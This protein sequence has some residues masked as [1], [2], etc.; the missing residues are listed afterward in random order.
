MR[1]FLKLFD[2]N[3]L[4][5]VL[6]RMKLLSFMMFAVLAA[7]AADT[8]S[9]SARFDMHIKDASVK[10]VFEHIEE[11]SEFILLYNEKWVD[12]NRKVSV[13]AKNESV[14]TVL[15]KIFEGTN[16]VFKIYDRQIVILNEE[17]PVITS[18]PAASESV[19]QQQRTINGRVTDTENEPLPGVTVLIK[20][21]RQGTVTNPDG[22]YSLSNVPEDAILVFSFVGMRSQEI[23]VDNRSSINVTLAIDAIGLEEIIAV[24]YGTQK[25]VN[26]TGSVSN[27]DV[28]NVESRAVTQSSQMLAGKVSGVTVTQ[29][30]GQPGR[31]ESNIVI[32]GLGTFSSAG[33]QPLVLV[34]GLASSIDNVNP[35][36]IESISVL[37]DAASAS[38]YG[39][40]AAN[41]VILIQTKRGTRAGFNISYNGY[42]GWKKVNEL[43]ENVN[44]WE[45]AMLTNEARNN[46]G[47]GNT[48]SQ[49]EIEL[50]RNGTDP[51]NYPNVNHLE[52]L[53]S[54]GSGF[55]TNHNLSF[56][57]MGDK[58]SYLFSVGYLDE[59][60]LVAKTNYKR[61]N[62]L[63]NFDSDITDNLK[64]AV[65]INGN[66]SSINEP[67]RNLLTN[68]V[69]SLIAYA[70]QVP[71]II[72]DRNS[73]G[74]YDHWHDYGITAIMD[75]NNFTRGNDGFF[76]GSINL[77]WELFD[78]FIL[79]GKLGYNYENSNRDSYQSIIRYDDVY[80]FGPNAL[81]VVSSDNSLIT[82]QAL[83]NYDLTINENNFHFLAGF[84]Q[85]EFRYDFMDAYRDNFPNDLL[86]E[87]DAG[88]AANMR[89]SGTAAEWALRSLFGR[90][91]YSYEG[92]YLLEG[93][94]RYDG[95]SRFPSDNRWAVFPSFSA[96]WRMSEES[97]MQD[98]TWLDNLKLR[99]SW[100][101]LGNQNI[102]NYPYQRLIT[103]GRDYPFGGARYPGAYMAAIANSEIEWERTEMTNIGLDF[104]I[105]N[106]KLDFVVDYFNKYTSGILYNISVSKVLGMGS[107]EVNAGEVKNTGIEAL[108]NYNQSIGNFRFNITPNF[109]YIHNE[110]MKI[111]NAEVDINQGLFVGESLGAI[112][113]YVADGLFVD[114]DDITDY[115]SQPYAVQPG[116]I[117]YKDISGPEGVPDGQVDPQYDRTVIGTRFPKFN[118]GLNV[119]ASYANFDFSLQL[120]GI[121]GNKNYLP[122]DYQQTAFVNG[123]TAQRWQMENRWTQ[124]NPDRNAEYPIMLIGSNNGLRF[125]STYWLRDAGFLQVKNLQIG[126][127]LPSNLLSSIGI[128]SSRIYVNG[129][130][131]YRF[132]NYYPGWDPEM[133]SGRGNGQFYPNTATYSLGLRVNF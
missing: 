2:Q 45:H 36:D 91:N 11:N 65:N 102:G 88:S 109:S 100:G 119:G 67:I 101:V 12:V 21:T 121:A 56:S 24:G 15:Q 19:V 115:P 32:R 46:V 78:N 93:N 26:L 1:N 53:L 131:I 13:D 75:N 55:Q 117:R 85:E 33:T 22:N 87:L 16:N 27:V 38:I 104:T 103:L 60:G 37:K 129:E 3:A 30:S 20:G 28:S 43:P 92:K 112:Y 126:Y 66:K 50:F 41:G 127:N 82:A 51:E 70:Q 110:V 79:T 105:L 42:A 106:N 133:G 111:A 86:Y 80:T 35:N 107:S 83:A 61:Y 29:Q 77:D 64:L 81:S 54:S 58:N 120:Q 57:S 68:N 73:D 108:I 124:E 49:A 123:G 76:L 47:Q 40:R 122:G 113:G 125:I 44:S 31:N 118:Y 94:V 130:N 97:F 128:Q 18:A 63:F 25:R 98:M 34:D 116:F 7:S 5:K 99:A 48:Y 14:E 72:G 89:N 23:P 17:R 95:T 90:I 114:N 74:T 71:S 6:L 4:S 59:N 10:E 39:T 9:Q 62:F 52:D 96:G 69:A 8:Y 84:S 132:D